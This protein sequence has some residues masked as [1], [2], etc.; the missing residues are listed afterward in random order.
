[1]TVSCQTKSC[2]RFHEARVTD[3]RRL[4][5]HLN[6]SIGTVSRALNNRPGV[7]PETREKV[8]RAATELGY[9][10]NQS[11]RA[12][13]KGATNTIGFVV[14]SGHPSNLGGDNFHFATID[15]MNARLADHG[16][17][18]VILPCH[19]ADDP[20]EFLARTV[21][22]GTVDA[23][24][25][26]ATRQQDKRIALLARSRM[27]FLTLGRSATPGDYPWIDLD[28]VSTAR[29]S[30][31][32]LVALGHR[33]IAVGLP[34]RDVALAHHYLAGFRQ[35]MAEAGLVVDDS[36]ILNAESS[37]SGGAALGAALLAHPARPTAVMLCS[38]IK[39][40]GLYAH[41]AGQGL[42][43]GRDLSVVVF[44][45][46]PQLRFLSP[47]VAG[48]QLSL[49]DLGAALADAVADLLAERAGAV[50]TRARAM[51]WPMTFQD[52]PSLAPAPRE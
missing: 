30:V 2:K 41:L 29:D 8:L 38:E 26:T 33:R 4:A 17:D 18:L 40:I 34:D 50:P 46:S 20:A 31:A 7:H 39:A 6:V 37:E 19:S 51:I 52:G 5:D 44:R 36:L 49:R 25:L 24:V 23:L 48:Y 45:Q 14:E 35:G 1:M 28:F 42:V 9:V 43:P 21:A 13:R 10:A 16:L 12:L 3:I 27:P 15:A 32:R 11:G 47:A 22:R